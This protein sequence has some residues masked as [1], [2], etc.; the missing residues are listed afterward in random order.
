ML[1][2]SHSCRGEG[3]GKMKVNAKE[4][5]KKTNGGKRRGKK[6]LRERKRGKSVFDPFPRPDPATCS[7]Y[8]CLS[9]RAPH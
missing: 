7:K 3:G 2:K 1:G 4:K 9:T 6:R 5:T 8:W